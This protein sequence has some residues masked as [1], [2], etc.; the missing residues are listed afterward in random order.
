MVAVLG[1][2][3][4]GIAS[5]TEAAAVGAVGAT[6]LTMANRKFSMKILQEVMQTTVRLTCMVFIILC[7]AAPSDWFSA[8]WAATPGE[9]FF[10]IPGR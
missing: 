3:F 6:L 2:I 8:G 4:A 5:P 7:G 10:R 1:S 9:G